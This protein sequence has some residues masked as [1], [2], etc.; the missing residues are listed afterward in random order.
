MAPAG[1]SGE[2]LN[3]Q[4]KSQLK[5]ATGQLPTDCSGIEYDSIVSE[6]NATPVGI[7]AP[8]GLSIY[9]YKASFSIAMESG[10]WEKKIQKH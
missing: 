5:F 3:A 4:I 10:L 9:R 6:F 8:S 2:I 7:D 1:A